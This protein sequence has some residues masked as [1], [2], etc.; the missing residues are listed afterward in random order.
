[1]ARRLIADIVRGGLYSAAFPR[2]GDKLVLV[3]SWDAINRGMRSP[4][5]CL[6][7]STPRERNLPT[8]VALPAGTAGNER[9]S[10][11]LCHELA[12]LDAKDIRQELGKIPT[13]LLVQVENALRRALDL[14]HSSAT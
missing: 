13:P 9:D 10:W 1:M 11:I 8:N 6:V 14:G 3:V 2:V 5:V 7:T 12:T 4:I